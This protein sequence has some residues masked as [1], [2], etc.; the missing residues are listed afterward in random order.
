MSPLEFEITRVDCISMMSELISL[1]VY[2]Y[3]NRNKPDQHAHARSD[4]RAFMNIKRYIRYVLLKII[5]LGKSD[6]P[7]KFRGCRFFVVRISVRPFLPAG[8]KSGKEYD[9]TN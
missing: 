5:L 2:P 6:V 4:I 8:S 1:L 3:A 7:I 9:L